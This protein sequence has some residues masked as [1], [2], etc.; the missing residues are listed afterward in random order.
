MLIFV[1][2]NLRRGLYFCA[3]LLASVAC[4]TTRSLEDGQY[5][6]RKNKIVVNDKAVTSGELGSYV[7][8]KPN[9][10]L[11]GLNPFLSIYNWGNDG[12][13]PMERFWETP[14]WSRTLRK[15]TRPSPASRTTFA[16]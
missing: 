5:L 10:Y 4:S 16:T 3:I 12:S 7:S 2:V 15:W 11:L 13:T 1:L 8:Q 6:L 9:S 14:L